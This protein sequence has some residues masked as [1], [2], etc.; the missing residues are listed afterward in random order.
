MDPRSAVILPRVL[1]VT[2][3][4]AER[5]GT[6]PAMIGV[7]KRC[8]RLIDNAPPGAF[9]PELLHF[10]S[11]PTHDPLTVRILRALP[12]HSVGFI[13]PRRE[14]AGLFRRIRPDIVVLGEAPVEGMM[15]A[16][17]R[18]ASATG[19]PIL[20]I[21]NY[22]GSCHFHRLLRDSPEVSQ[23]LL[24]GL[25]EDRAMCRLARRVVLAPPLLDSTPKQPSG[26]AVVTILGYDQAVVRRGVALASRLPDG[27]ALRIVGA[28]ADCI[29]ANSDRLRC[30]LSQLDVLPMPTETDLRWLLTTSDVVV[31]KSGFQQMVEALAVGT[32]VLA[33][34]RPGAIPEVW[35]PLAFRPFV[36]Y[37]PSGTRGWSTCLCAAVNW[38]AKRPLMPWTAE[39]SAMDRPVEITARRLVRMVIDLFRSRRPQEHE[40]RVRRGYYNSLDRIVE[41]A[42]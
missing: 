11:L 32:P 10:G 25:G 1:F 4:V 3:G 16:V 34:E 39:I 8:L 19:V 35:L 42:Q 5:T 24:L 26:R 17:S 27:I 15:K 29:S 40:G 33:V 37:L 18:H 6:L 14:I 30:R 23:W 13:E 7:L 38:I 21:D 41:L 31:C 20:C 9:K 28:G 12:T 22:Y 36:H 2:Y